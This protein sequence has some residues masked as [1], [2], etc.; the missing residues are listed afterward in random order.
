MKNKKKIILIAVIAAVLLCAA[1]VCAAVL[2]KPQPVDKEPEPEKPAVENEVKEEVKEEVADYDNHVERKAFTVDK[3]LLDNDFSKTLDLTV[4][5]KYHKSSFF[6]CKAELEDGWAHLTSDNHLFV[7]G[8]HTWGAYGGIQF[9][10]G[11]TYTMSF[12]LKKG[13]ENGNDIFVLN[14]AEEKEGEDPRYGDQLKQV[15]LDF[16]DIENMCSFNSDRGT[17]AAVQYTGETGI[18]HV[19]IRFTVD[20]GANN[21]LVNCHDSTTLNDWLID[22]LYIAEIT[23]EGSDFEWIVE[24]TKPTY[25][26]N[27]NP[28]SNDYYVRFVLLDE[29]FNTADSL[30]LENGGRNAFFGPTKMTLDKNAARL[31]TGQHLFTFGRF[32]AWGNNFGGVEFEKDHQYLMSFDLKLGD[33]RTQKV[34][35]LYIMQEDDPDPRFGSV[36]NTLKLDFN[37]LYLEKKSGQTDYFVK[38]NTNQF[39]SVKY[40]SKTRTAHIEI[41]FTR[42]VEPDI[43]VVSKGTGDNEWVLD[44]IYVADITPPV[45]V[46]KYDYTNGISLDQYVSKNEVFYNDF[47]EDVNKGVIKSWHKSAFFGSEAV[48]DGGAARLTSKE[49]LF[50]YGPHTWGF[51]GG[52]SLAKGATY[53][54]SFD[55]KLGDND[56]N[57]TFNLYVMSE[58]GDP[59]FSNVEKTLTLNYMDYK[60]LVTQNTNNFASV[61]YSSSSDW[62][63]I[64]IVFTTD[65]NQNTEIVSRCRGTNN[66]LI[67]NVKF[68]EVS[69]VCQEHVD[70]NGDGIC[71]SCGRKI[72]AEKD[73][74]NGIDF[75]NY[76]TVSTLFENDFE[77]NVDK[78]VTKE[79][80]KSA[81]FGSTASLSAGSARI[82]SD[83]HVFVYGG[84]SWGNYGSVSMAKDTMYKASFDLKLGDEDA[85]HIFNLYVT[86][87]NGDPR[88]GDVMKTL[89]LNFADF[90][91]F[92]TVNTDNFA[93]VRYTAATHT[94]HIEVLFKSDAEKKTLLAAHQAGLNDWFVDNLK[95]EQVTFVCNEHKDDNHDGYCDICGREIIGEKDYDNGVTLANTSV[96]S[97]AYENDFSEDANKGVTQPWHKSPYFGSAVALKDGQVQITSDEHVFVYGGHTY[98]NYGGMSFEKDTWYKTSFDIQLGSQDA[99]KMFTLYVMTENG[100]PRFGNIVGT[101]TLDFSDFENFVTENTGNFAHVTYDAA[102]HTAH[103]EALFKTDADAKTQLVSRKEGSNNWLMDNLQIA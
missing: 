76:E 85:T 75:A 24:D 52:L 46:T 47:S 98:G 66:W 55:L 56:A 21:Y 25:S 3:V 72:I 68:E 16:S 58:N 94:A 93:S 38:E 61:T 33:A 103:V 88:Y 95:I 26:C 69:L 12:D 6:G 71:D 1:G 53:K 39:A 41:R 14:L 86:K 37:D 74:F 67:D 50:T 96:V 45:N 42:T 11:K 90:N 18:C 59:R 49:H 79:W 23:E 15:V 10:T 54:M 64:E 63:H 34:F 20:R 92:V 84:H 101:L 57:R 100:D 91:H 44:N 40:D 48:L 99:N 8:W 7:F 77:E 29:K 27:I 2:L 30:K 80:E 17:F 28:R 83:E 32:N 70:N 97:I 81:F 35:N 73:Y 22:N 19:E 36:L 9:E 82:T 5:E 31:T 4:T 43:Q 60:N 62:A 65:K 13:S 102:S 87:E 89:T 51:Y 78:G